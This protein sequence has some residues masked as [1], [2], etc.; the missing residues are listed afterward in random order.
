MRERL[1]LVG[2]KLMVKSEPNRGTEIFAEVSLA[3]AEK[4]ENQNQ[5]GGG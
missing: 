5:D 4:K 1:R 2:G 3:T